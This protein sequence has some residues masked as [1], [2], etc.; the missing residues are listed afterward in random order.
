MSQPAASR[1]AWLSRRLVLL[2]AFVVAA[3][4]LI[5]MVLTACRTEQDARRHPFA[6]FF[7][8]TAASF[9]TVLSSG[10]FGK[11]YLNS[12]LVALAGVALAVTF[13]AFAA[14]AFAH[15]RFRGRQL[16]FLLFLL[17]MMVPV[18]VTLIPLNRLMAPGV[19]GLKGTLW[20]LIGPY[21][22]FALPISILILRGAFEAVPKE[23]MEAARMDGCTAWG[24]FRHVGLPLVRPALATVTIFNLLTMWN[25][26]AFALV[27]VDGKNA[28]LP[29]AIS[30]F[31]GEN[32]TDITLICA[33]LAVSVLPLLAVY[34]VAQKH[35]IRGLT[36]GALKQ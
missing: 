7:T 35:I 20:A 11:A 14:F 12:A 31:Q 19:L 5:W 17:G 36:A 3:Y 10:L 33:A 4:P 27:L 24:V 25:E 6:L 18:H 34:F 2:L 16:L 26:F 1:L 32:A 15:C 21:V 8:P 13:A 29:L 23:L 28:T 30:Q 22:G 9:R